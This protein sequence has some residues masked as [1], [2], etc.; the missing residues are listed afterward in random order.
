[1][2]RGCMGMRWGSWLRVAAVVGLVGGAMTLGR[3][4]T[5]AHR[6]AQ[7]VERAGLRLGLELQALDGAALRPGGTARLRIR[8]RSQADGQA[9]PRILPGVWIDTAEPRDGKAEAEHPT[10][11]AACAQRIRRYVRASGLNPQAVID[12]NGYDVLALNTDAS[13]SVLD[14]RTVFAGKTSLKASLPLPGPGVDWAADAQDSRLFVSI[15][16]PPSVAVADLLTLQPEPGVSLPGPPGRVRLQP[17]GQRVWV[18]VARASN[19][20]PGGVAL[21][22]TQPP[23]TMRWLPLGYGA[24]DWAF[25]PA[26]WVAV[27]QADA[28]QVVFV[29]PTADRIARREALPAQAAPVSVVFDAVGRRFWVADTHHGLLRSYDHRGQPLSAVPVGAGIGAQAISPDGRWLMVANPTTDEVTVLDLSAARLAHR[30]RVPGRPVEI[31]FTPSH[32]YVRTLESASLT[33]IGLAA[34]ETRPRVQT[35]PLGE[36]PASRRPERPL[37]SALAIMADGAGVFAASPADNAIFAYMEGMNAPSGSVSAKGHELLAVRLVRRGLREVDTGVFE[38]QFV[39]P[40][41]LT[42]MWLAVAIERPRTQ[43]CVRVPLGPAQRPPLRWQLVWQSLPER[44]DR[45]VVQL[46]GVPEDQL[47]P[48][49]WLRLF[50]PGQPALTVPAQASAPGQYQAALPQ[51]WPGLWYVHALPPP[52][53][54]TRWP[55]VSFQREDHEP[56]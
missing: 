17:D 2:T 49:L 22:D 44:D 34:L 5:E 18:G 7:D 23:R 15:P 26:G 45:L 10:E 42:E 14:P 40:A 19:Q 11:E 39:V 3:A 25:D 53:A 56:K 51:L 13:I 6:W 21:I 46:H 16:N 28:A 37:A 9:L 55:Y 1:M 8:V 4:Q 20:G 43:Y 41:H 27:V 50:Q 35:V 12:F 24:V 31:A 30:I 47:P 48:R 52:Q 54:P 36:H 38:Q 29:D 32:A 33:L